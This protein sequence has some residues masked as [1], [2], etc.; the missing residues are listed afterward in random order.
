MP[1]TET[2]ARARTLK[3]EIETRIFIFVSFGG[4]ATAGVDDDD[5]DE[6]DEMRF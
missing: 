2:T 3:R 4:V 5:D 1:E 6:I